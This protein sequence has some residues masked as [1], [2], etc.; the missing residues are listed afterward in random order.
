[1]IS[2]FLDAKQCGMAGAVET[3]CG[4][5]YGAEQYK[6]LGIYTYAAIMSLLFWLVFQY[7]SYGCSQTNY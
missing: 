6:K 5:A 7:L 2:E 1:M 4:Q 3:L